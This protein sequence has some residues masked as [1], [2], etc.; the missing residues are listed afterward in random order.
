MK[1]LVSDKHF[2]ARVREARET[3]AKCGVPV[4]GPGRIRGY[5]AW[6]RKLRAVFRKTQ[7]GEEIAR[8]LKSI[9]NQA[10]SE[11]EK[12]RQRLKV[13]RTM[14]PPSPE[15]VIDHLLQDFG[16][17]PNN[18]RYRLFL[19]THIFFHRE[20]F[21]EPFSLPVL[22]RNEKTGEM[23]LYLKLD[24]HTKKKRILAH[25]DLIKMQLKTLPGYRA[26]NR[27]WETFER[28]LQIYDAYRQVQQ[29]LADEAKRKEFDTHRVD[30]L[31]WRRLN[32]INSLRFG[33]MSFEQLRKA[34]SRVAALGYPVKDK[35]PA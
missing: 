12:M 7:N 22:K 3:W 33:N 4:P 31:V 2:Q 25:W 16:F 5:G 9:N 8:A 19:I 14:L 29:E 15:A 34:K 1:I 24:S 32:K 13:W 10:I 17:D 28:D 23:E 21:T 20:D 30:E 26:R 27:R 6:L 11:N 18:T 35:E